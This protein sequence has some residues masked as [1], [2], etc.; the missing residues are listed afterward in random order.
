MIGISGI[1]LRDKVEKHVGLF[2]ITIAKEFRG[3]GLGTKFMGMNIDEATKNLP[4][5]EI[6]ILAVYGENDLARKM[7]QN[8]GFRE[9]GMLP[10]GLKR[11]SGYSDHV[12]MYKT[13]R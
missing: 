7:Y 11:E 2:G 1:D 8:F 10:K 3:K 5:L 13:V 4:D 12:F 6:I 9:Y